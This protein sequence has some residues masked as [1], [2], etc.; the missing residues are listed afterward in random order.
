MRR[1]PSA[2]PWLLALLL[3]TAPSAAL[4]NAA[5]LEQASGAAHERG[6]DGAPLVKRTGRL[7][8]DS[9]VR[10]TLSV[11]A[12]ACVVAVLA[13]AKGEASLG[14]RALAADLTDADA[15][16]LAR[17]RYCAAE[18]EE[19]VELSAESSE[20]GPFVV[21]AWRVGAPE[22]EKV[23]IA[24]VP[25]PAPPPTESLPS[26]LGKL[27]HGYEPMAPPRE[28]DLSEGDP[29]KREL[30]LEAGRCYRAFAVGE[31]QAG[32][33]E[34]LLRNVRGSGLR[35]V[36]KVPLGAGSTARTGLVCPQQ[37]EPHV[38]EIRLRN[39]SGLVLWQLVGMDNPEISK[40]W[41]VG[42]EGQALVHKKMRS[43]RARSDADR[44]P[45]MA[46]V[47]GALKTNEHAEAKFSV[48]P[49]RC[50]GALTVGVPSLRALE[51]ELYDQRGDLVAQTRG[52]SVARTQACA[53]VAGEWS[54]KVR[55][56][57]GYGD[58]GL[59]VFAGSED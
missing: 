49:G 40:R 11:P 37:T 7:R 20:R 54:V 59:Q 45:A 47:A 39:G 42:G 28:E 13:V 6:G 43:E 15:G 32:Q 2:I 18:R 58:Y 26:R 8:A 48:V 51:L 22:P 27:T 36:G 4:A 1:L 5:L 55:A 57:K 16:Q 17:L 23:A 52:D 41:L 19:K 44:L 53:A 46:F 31:V 56:F 21:G 24:P 50:Y 10:T 14:L 12:S 29:R 34:L 3:S 30:V 9:P 33:L 25:A 38:L 35:S